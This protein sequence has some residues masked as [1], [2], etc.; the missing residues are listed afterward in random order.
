MTVA[1]FVPLIFSVL[2]KQRNIERRFIARKGPRKKQLQRLLVGN[3]SAKKHVSG[4]KIALKQKN[5]V[6]NMAM[7]VCYNHGRLGVS[8][9]LLL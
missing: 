7:L 5:G 4:A 1:K 9:L 2:K 6:F 3:G 8:N